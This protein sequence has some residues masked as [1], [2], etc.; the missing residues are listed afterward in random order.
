MV[1]WEEAAKRPWLTVISMSLSGLV[2]AG[3]YGYFGFGD[4]IGYGIA[5]GVG[6]ALMI[7]RLCWQT[8]HDPVRVR[9]LSERRRSPI[10]IGGDVIR[11]ALPFLALVIAAVAGEATGSAGVFVVSSVIV[12]RFVPR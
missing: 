2:A 4:S 1:S 8:V 6:V 11:V 10:A 3:L 9:E 5:L 12:R 7:A